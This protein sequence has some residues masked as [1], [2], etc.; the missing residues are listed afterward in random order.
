MQP[1]AARYPAANLVA[2]GVLIRREHASQHTTD[3]GF[4]RTA[5][6]QLQPT[7]TW[8]SGIQ[9]KVHALRQKLHTGGGRSIHIYSVVATAE[10]LVNMSAQYR[11][12]CRIALDYRP[13]L[14]GVAQA[15]AINPGAT[16]IHWVVMQAHQHMTLASS[17]K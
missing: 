10:L 16:D 5:V 11:P 6:I 17:L 8:R 12:D 4:Q 7:I 2:P 1:G 3:A 9:G 14:L 15:D 13:E